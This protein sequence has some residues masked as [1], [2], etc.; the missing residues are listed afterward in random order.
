MKVVT[1]SLAVGLLLV[2][3]PFGCLMLYLERGP[4]DMRVLRV[5]CAVQQEAQ[6]ILALDY[7]DR[8]TW[9]KRRSNDGTWS[10]YDNED[11]IGSAGGQG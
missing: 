1:K 3:H 4:C 9:K 8:R 5:K 6:L 10:L 2:Y 11:N 7:L